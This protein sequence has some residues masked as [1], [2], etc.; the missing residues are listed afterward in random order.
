MAIYAALLRAVN[1]G[2]TGK[3][4]M[5]ELRELCE[6]IGFDGVR[7]YI[8]SGN[9][10]FHADD[11][12][13]GVQGR[14][15]QALETLAGKPVGVLVRTAAQ[16]EAVIAADPYQGRA[17]NLVHVVFLDQAPPSDVLVGVSGRSVEEIAPGLREIYVHY[18]QGQGASK[19]RLP[20]AAA[21]T[22]RNM[23][24]VRKI[25]ELANS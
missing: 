7:T 12:E 20:A 2:G 23:N 18:P 25:T 6:R 21:G 11:D 14:L 10:I 9:V 16:L 13:A 4:S 22:A 3:L 5:D 24:T 8:A 17:S 19:L 15:A 1:V